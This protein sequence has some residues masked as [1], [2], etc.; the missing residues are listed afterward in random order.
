LGK[1]G[2]VVNIAGAAVYL[3]SDAAKWATGAIFNM[4]D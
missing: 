2:E 4:A 1:I 3:A